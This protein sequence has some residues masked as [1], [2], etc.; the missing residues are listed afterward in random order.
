MKIFLLYSAVVETVC[1]NIVLY[2]LVVV[3]YKK[4]KL[5]ANG[6]LSGFGC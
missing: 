3:G 4:E 1:D 2:L 5:I 6:W